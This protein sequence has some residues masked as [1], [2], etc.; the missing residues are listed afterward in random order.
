MKINSLYLVKIIQHNWIK[1]LLNQK[2]KYNI[3]HW[4]TDTLL[5]TE[6]QPVVRWFENITRI[7]RDSFIMLVIFLF[8]HFL[9]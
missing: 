1:E 3:I 7:T 8:M 2:S 4:Y 6:Y 5:A 9:N